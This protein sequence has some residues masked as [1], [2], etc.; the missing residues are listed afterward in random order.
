[1]VEIEATCQTAKHLTQAVI[2]SK[3]KRE[4]STIKRSAS[5]SKVKV[6]A[7]NLELLPFS[8]L[9]GVATF[10]S[11]CFGAMLPAYVSAYL[12]QPDAGASTGWMRRGGQG[13]V[14]GAM[15]SAGFLTSFAGLG[16][17]FGLVGSTL[18]RY[19]P[20]I[21][22]LIALFIVIMGIV[23]LVRPAFSPSLGGVAGR[24]L[25]PKAGQGLSS[26][27]V[28]GIIYAI[29]A[30]ACTLPIFLSIMVQTFISSGGLAGGLL[31]FLAYGWGMSATML[32]FSV[33]LASA[34][35]LVFKLFAPITRWVQRASGAFMIL[36]GGYVLYY[37]LIYGRYLDELLR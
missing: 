22:V 6:E 17:L 33:L 23:M 3:L 35:G 25:Q 18:G 2:W 32:L 9:A 11:P 27:Y 24:W 26:F 13:L 4:G 15:V 7:M 12:G 20:W 36:A 28:Y 21:A 10:F 37:L 34:K 8:F 19:L 14:L 31:S 29:C 30:A 16:A 1:M 5:W